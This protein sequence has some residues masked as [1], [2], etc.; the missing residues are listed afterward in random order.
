MYNKSAKLT[1]LQ[2]IATGYN[3]KIYTF[4]MVIPLKTRVYKTFLFN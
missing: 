4:F 2:R 3:L 1:N